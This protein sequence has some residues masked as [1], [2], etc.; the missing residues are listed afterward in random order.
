MHIGTYR[1]SNARKININTGF[2]SAVMAVCYPFTFIKLSASGRDNIC[3]ELEREL[4]LWMR[5]EQ[6]SQR[7]TAHIPRSIPIFVVLFAFSQSHLLPRSF[8]LGSPAHAISAGFFRLLSIISS[9]SVHVFQQTHKKFVF[10]SLSSRPSFPLWLRSSFSIF[11]RLSVRSFFMW[12]VYVPFRTL[13]AL[14]LS[15]HIRWC[16]VL[17]DLSINKFSFWIL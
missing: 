13:N 9:F 11:L 4:P 5:A 10:F 15:S 2:N 1:N 7:R 12:F 6:P 16:A 3:C 17:L 8:Q 14:F